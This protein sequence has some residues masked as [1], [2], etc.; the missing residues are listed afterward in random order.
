MTWQWSRVNLSDIPQE[1]MNAIKIATLGDSDELELGDQ[2]G[3]Y[4][5]RSWVYGQ[6]VTS[7]Y[8]SAMDRDLTLTDNSGNTIESTGLIQTDAPI[9]SGRQRR[10]P[11]LKI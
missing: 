11:S 2:G 9:N 3:G 6:S 1:T 10:R 8:V 4:R 5:K 7:G